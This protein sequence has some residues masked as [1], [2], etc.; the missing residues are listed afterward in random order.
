MLRD[1]IHFLAHPE[2]LGSGSPFLP[3]FCL[4][5]EGR[6]DPGLHGEAEPGWLAG[7]GAQAGAA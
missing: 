6:E 3:V 2:C 7:F 5:V 1:Q 4:G